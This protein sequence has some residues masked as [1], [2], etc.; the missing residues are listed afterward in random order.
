METERNR[1]FPRVLA[2][3]DDATKCPCIG[4]VF[5]AG[6][7]ATPAILRRW[8]A[9][10]VRDSKLLTAKRRAALAPVIRATALAWSVREI[11]PAMIDGRV[12][13][14]LL[15]MRV[16]LDVL[17]DLLS[18]R[19]DIER[20]RLDNWE[21]TREHFFRRLAEAI[22]AEE[23]RAL[24]PGLEIRP[25]HYADENHIVV[26]AASILAK[27]G[28]ERQYEAYKE[29]YGDFGSGSPGD[30]KTRRFVWIHRADPPPIVR[31]SWR[32][33]RAIFPL[34]DIREDPVYAW[35]TSG[36][37]HLSPRGR[38]RGSRPKKRRRVTS[39]AD[40]RSRRMDRLRSAGSEPGEKP[41]AE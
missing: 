5:V 19:P 3:I 11:T 12:N 31:R 4:S 17:R 28:S 2:G 25:E 7:V 40:A 35:K 39:K 20:L 21:V 29:I 30:P 41:P 32:T 18:F 13:L 15:E 9:L 8:K 27:T 24:A 6:V 36:H 33:C 1:R 16:V 14:N 23:L 37:G 34:S 10:G 38:P 22:P 26:G